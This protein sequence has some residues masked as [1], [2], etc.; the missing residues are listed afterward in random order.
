MNPPAPLNFQQTKTS[1]QAIW[2]LI[3][4]ILSLF[5]LWIFGSIPAIVLGILALRNIDRSGGALQGRGLGIAGII[6][7][8]V[9]MITGISVVA[10]MASIFLPVMNSARGQAERTAE[11]SRASAIVSACIVYASANEGRFPESLSVLA[12]HGIIQ[13]EFLESTLAPGTT[14]LYRP[15]LTIDARPSEILLASPVALHGRRVVYWNGAAEAISE[16]TFQS[17]YAHL[18]P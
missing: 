9:G 2:S 11:A 4:G 7:G 5:C 8:G 12:Q 6:T 14:F 18:F 10:M 1:A 3:L 16:V 13:A 17:E 15:G